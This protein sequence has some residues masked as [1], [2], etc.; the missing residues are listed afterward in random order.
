MIIIIKTFCSFRW[1]KEQSGGDCCKEHNNPL[2]GYSGLQGTDPAWSIPPEPALSW[3]LL[4]KAYSSS[5]DLMPHSPVTQ[6][7]VTSPLSEGLPIQNFKKTNCLYLLVRANI[8][9]TLEGVFFFFFFNLVHI[10]KK[11]QV[12]RVEYVSQKLMW[13]LTCPKAQNATSFRNRVTTYARKRSHWT[14]N[15]ESQKLNLDTGRE[16]ASDKR[17]MSCSYNSAN[18]H[19]KLARDAEGFYPGS[20][21]K[22][23]PAH[24]SIP[25]LQPPD[26]EKVNFYSFKL[27]SVC[28]LVT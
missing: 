12:L 9:S 22:H 4:N 28:Y 7:A 27:P 19:Q 13:K 20:Q 11:A 24:T 6:P 17:Q 10:G 3:G 21:M 25:D 2:R 8:G 26:C 18:H 16:R 14:L 1:R 15:P 5:H 23:D